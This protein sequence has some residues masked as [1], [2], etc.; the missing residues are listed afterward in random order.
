MGVETENVYSLSTE[1]QR[2]CGPKEKKMEKEIIRVNRHDSDSAW[3]Q[4]P[5]EDV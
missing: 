3:G 4:R 2:Q 1:M 5:A